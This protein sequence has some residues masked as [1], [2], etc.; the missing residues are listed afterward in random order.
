MLE[1][2]LFFVDFLQ[3]QDGYLV[4]NPSVSPENTYI[5]PSGE[6][7]AC[8][9][10]ATMDFE[11]LNDLFGACIKATKVLQDE[12]LSFAIPGVDDVQ[13][14]PGQLEQILKKLPPIRIDST[15]RIME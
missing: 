12:E 10:G 5:L 7:G 2:A 8:C 4:T 11:I 3:E 13:A 14:L 9:V 15:G 1:A 6:S